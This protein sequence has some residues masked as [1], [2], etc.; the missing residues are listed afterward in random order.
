MLGGG[1]GNER[2]DVVHGVEN[3]PKDNVVQAVVIVCHG[4]VSKHT[5]R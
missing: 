5:K 2:L 3:R 1:Y 4:K